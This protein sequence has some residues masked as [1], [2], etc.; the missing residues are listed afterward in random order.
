LLVGLLLGMTPAIIAL[1]GTSYVDAAFTAAVLATWAIGLRILNGE[2]DGSAAL[3]FGIATGLAIGIKPTG[4]I[5]AVP[6]LVAVTFLLLT[7]GPHATRSRLVHLA[8]LGLPALALGGSWYLKNLFAH[9]NPFHPVGLGPFAGLEP[10]TYGSPLEPSALVGLSALAKVA[11]SWTYDWQ[12]HGYIYNQRPGGLG[13]GWLAVVALG[14]GGLVV[15]ARRGAW[16]PLVFV[17]APACFAV[18]AMASPW[19]AR[20]TLFLPGLAL[21]LSALFLDRFSRIL[22]LA[23]GFGL[24]MLAS[25][26]VVLANAYP[27]IPVP[28]PP[29][30]DRATGYWGIVFGDPT[31]LAAQLDAPPRCRDGDLRIPRGARVAVGNTFPTPHAVVGPA[32]DRIL[33]QPPPAAADVE[34]LV[35]IMRQKQAGWLV[36]QSGSTIDDVAIGAPH[37]F[38]PRGRICREGR[39]YELNS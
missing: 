6:I 9:G 36:A 1:A 19:Y 7:H 13:H 5:L 16:R 17:V 14:L 10:G 31:G 29:G 38:L 4:L 39:V 25:I 37:V 8:A 2:R 35:A 3:L 26:S 24:V 33:V 21:P 28:L 20:Y 34:S 22:R 15:L 23:A 18:A 27:N 12:L 11:V 30:S 32:R